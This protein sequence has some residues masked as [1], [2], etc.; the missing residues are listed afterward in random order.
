MTTKTYTVHR[1]MQDGNR[2]YLP[3][4]TRELTEADA[5]ELVSLGALSLE[6]EDPVERVP[7]VRHAF[8]AEPSAVND[9]GY[10]IADE[11]MAIDLAKP[12]KTAKAE[13]A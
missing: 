1:T 6:G 4:D 7:G 12:G 13:K 10:T 11:S 9:A 5:A 2:G 8:G 3:G